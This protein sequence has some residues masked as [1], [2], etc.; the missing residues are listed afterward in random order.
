MKK[1]SLLLVTAFLFFNANAQNVGIGTNSPTATLDVAGTVRLRNGSAAGKVLTSDV[2]GNATWSTALRPG[3]VLSENAADPGL[4]ANNYSNISSALLATKDAVNI[5]SLPAVWTSA[6]KFLAPRTIPSVVAVNGNN[7]A[8]FGGY[9]A[10]GYLS[11]GA[12]YNTVTDTWTPIPDIGDG[13]ERTVPTVLW[14]GTKLLVWGGYKYANNI[15]TYY[16]SGALYDPATKTWSPMITT[17]APSG[18]QG[19]AV[20]YNA[21]TKEVA[22]W[23]GVNSGGNVVLADGAKYKVTTNSWTP[24]ATYPPL[25]GR[26]SM[27]SATSGGKLFIFGG[28]SNTYS[29]QAYLYD[30]SSDSWFTPAVC[31]LS[32]RTAAKV[33]TVN[34]KFIVWSGNTAGTSNVTDGAYYNPVNDSWTLMSTVGV[35]N[36]TGGKATVSNNY[37]VVVGANGCAKYD[38]GGN[39]WSPID[40]QNRAQHGLAGNASC[41]F[42]FGGATSL[43]NGAP[44]LE[45]GSR[46]FWNAQTITTHID[47]AMEVYL[48]RK[49]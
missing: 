23:G 47:N 8:V 31:P 21:G 19:Y 40:Q 12:F 18:R 4:L 38:V 29:S 15:Y 32:A 1:T 39:A 35:P 45:N 16:N 37:F 34:G 3:I 20:G 49:N 22:I 5:T 43:Q 26:Y 44:K 41:M 7:F 17:G 28:F 11:N 48:Y 46:F 42:T 33:E 36:A 14:V 9:D 24:M 30:F 6:T 2:N 27:G 25:T 13:I 10:T